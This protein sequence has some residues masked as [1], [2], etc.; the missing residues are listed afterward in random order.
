MKETPGPSRLDRASP[1]PL[2]AQLHSDISRRL[3][4]G[5]F[6]E[7][8]PAEMSLVAQYG[9]SR[10]TVREAMRRFRTDGVVVAA[11]GGAP[12]WQLRPR[13]SSPSARFTVSSRR[14]RHQGWSNAALFVLSMSESI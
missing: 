6:A 1:V 8:F 7:T 4:A 13:S 9:V 12:D 3:E 2:W 11:R 14:W 5:E 10:N